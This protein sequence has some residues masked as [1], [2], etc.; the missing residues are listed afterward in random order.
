MK[1]QGLPPHPFYL[2]TE[3]QSDLGFSSGK[4]RMFRHGWTYVGWVA[5][6]GP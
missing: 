6:L 3:F 4:Q 5:A 1:N 2:F